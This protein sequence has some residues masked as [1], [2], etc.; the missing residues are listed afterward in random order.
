MNV[1]IKHYVNICSNCYWVKLVQHKPYGQLQ[2]LPLAASPFS[3]ITID[4]ITDLLPC[5][6][7]SQV[8]NSILVFVDRYTKIA[9]Y[10]P[11]QIDWKA[12]TM[13]NVIAKTLLWKHSFP[14]VFILDRGNLFT[15]HYWK[16]FCA[17]LRIHCWYSIAFHF[18]TDRQIE[19]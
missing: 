5:N 2:L 15:T 8:F 18:Q 11:S 6:Q 12:K 7:K 4:F 19:W 14:E 16:A 10:I 13:A 9:M 1:N 17:H 3:K